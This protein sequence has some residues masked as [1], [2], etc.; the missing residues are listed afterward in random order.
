MNEKGRIGKLG[1]ERL[2]EKHTLNKSPKL[3]YSPSLG[4]GGGCRYLKSSG[5]SASGIIGSGAASSFDGCCILRIAAKRS[6]FAVVKW[7]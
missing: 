4:G 1:K 6:K 7:V 5:S 2:G 3:L